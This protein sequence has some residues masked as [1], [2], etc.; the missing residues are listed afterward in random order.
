MSN[1]KIILICLSITYCS[2]YAADGILEPESHYQRYRLSEYPSDQ[3]FFQ[4]WYFCIKDLKNNQYYAIIYGMTKSTDPQKTNQGASVMFGTRE[5]Q[6]EKMTGFTKYEKY[7]LENL[8][9][10]NEF[11]YQL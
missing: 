4:W 1:L 10:E 7:E 5:L 6:N 3:P 2:S 11:D 8:Q 9:V